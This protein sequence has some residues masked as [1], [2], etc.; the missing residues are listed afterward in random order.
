MKKL[1]LAV[2]A[3][4]F[5]GCGFAQEVAEV[6]QEIQD[7]QT[8]QTAPV[9][10]P[11]QDD[12]EPRIP[13]SYW[14]QIL[15]SDEMR[16]F[17]EEHALPEDKARYL[18]FGA[19]IPTHNRESSR[20][21]ALRMYGEGRLTAER[22]LH[23]S[24]GIINHE[25]ALTQLTRLAT[26]DGQ[27]PVAD[28]I[29]RRFVQNGRTHPLTSDEVVNPNFDMTGLENVFNVSMNRALDDQMLID[30]L[31]L[32][33]QLPEYVRDDVIHEVALLNLM[34]RVNS[35]LEAVE[36]AK[37]FLTGVFEFTVEE[38]LAIP[39]L[40]AW[41]YGRA[42]FIARYAVEAG[43]LQ[44]DETWPYLKMAADRAA[45]S[46]SCWREYAAAHTLGRALAFGNP[47][48]DRIAPMDYLLNHYASPF[49]ITPF[50]LE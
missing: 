27:T 2:C 33:M 6:M 32:A 4:V 12:D 24:W 9:D 36:G 23:D 34:E 31:M 10:I 43:F 35:G 15:L 40:A 45:A 1:L 16:A 11:A 37:T 18:V 38:L 44:E 25:T 46:Y 49:Q 21:F 41:D 19:F 20:V 26:A 39:T 22:L 7:A 50:H 29:F 17:E 30:S 13:Y 28:D 3:F 14:T 47:S 5:V 8:A 48:W 42:A